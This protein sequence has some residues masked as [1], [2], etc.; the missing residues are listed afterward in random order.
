MGSIKSVV[1][2]LHENVGLPS[3]EYQHVHVK[4]LLLVTL[5]RDIRSTC[6]VCVGGGGIVETHHLVVDNKSE[7]VFILVLL[8]HQLGG[9]RVSITLWQRGKEKDIS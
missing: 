6:C 5:T 1:C 2:I 9:V 3:S 8:H 4:H 7:D